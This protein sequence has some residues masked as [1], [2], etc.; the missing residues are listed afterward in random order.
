MKCCV[1]THVGTLTNWL[2]FEPDPDH[3]LDAGTGLLSPISYERCYAE[4]YVGKIP[5]VRIG[6]PP[7]QRGVVL[8]WFY[9]PSRRNTFVGGTCVLSS[10]LVVSLL[11]TSHKFRRNPFSIRV[12]RKKSLCWHATSRQRGIVKTIAYAAHIFQRYKTIFKNR[13]NKMMTV[14]ICWKPIYAEAMRGGGYYTLC[15]E[16]KHPLLFSCIT[17]RKSTQFEWK[18]HSK[19]LMKCWF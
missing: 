10:A 3:S 8:K 7:L 15:S 9:S 17:L 16:K 2:T 4:F 12:K 11:I 6:G 5:R 13:A 14:M 1:S 18:Y 19:Q